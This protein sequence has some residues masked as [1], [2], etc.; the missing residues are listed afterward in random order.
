M[1][2]YTIYV[3]VFFNDVLDMI[4]YSFIERYLVR[5]LASVSPIRY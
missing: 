5:R 2:I 1:Y 3:Y 4:L